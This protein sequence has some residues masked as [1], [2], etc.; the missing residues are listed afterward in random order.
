MT[1]IY[2]VL[3]D[4][5]NTQAASVCAP[6]VY[7][8]CWSFIFSFAYH[9]TINSRRTQKK[10]KGKTASAEGELHA[11]NQIGREWGRR[12]DLK[13][14]ITFD[15]WELEIWRAGL[16]SSTKG[17]PATTTTRGTTTPGDA[18]SRNRRH[19]A[20]LYKAKGLAIQFMQTQ[21]EEGG[22]GLHSES[23]TLHRDRSVRVTTFIFVLMM[24]S[25]FI[26][27]GTSFPPFFYSNTAGDPFTYHH[28]ERPT[29]QVTIV[30]T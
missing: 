1:Y 19:K 2:I 3:C 24:A 6:T 11:D 20:N 7:V 4:G 9:F 18:R 23:I 29:K 27:K 25:L 10:R 14:K 13:T 21:G 15:R 30:V 12:M 8:H 26:V 17:S 22:I 28:C 16:F 5:I